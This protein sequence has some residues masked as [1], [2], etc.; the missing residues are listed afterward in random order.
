MAAIIGVQDS[1]QH[2]GPQLWFLQSL[3]GKLTLIV[4]S[5]ASRSLRLCSKQGQGCMPFY[6]AALPHYCSTAFIQPGATA[7]KC[8]LRLWKDNHLT[9]HCLQRTGPDTELK[10]VQPDFQS[11]SKH[12]SSNKSVCSAV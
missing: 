12:R 9:N 3:L 7:N 2:V 8:L 1:L 11:S 10:Q 4:H 6:L 5:L